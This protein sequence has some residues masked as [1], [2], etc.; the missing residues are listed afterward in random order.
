MQIQLSVYVPKEKVE[1]QKRLTQLGI[2]NEIVALTFLRLDC[3]LAIESK[4]LDE[5]LTMKSLKSATEFIDVPDGR[6]CTVVIELED[7]D[8]ARYL[9]D[10]LN[11]EVVSE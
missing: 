1:K 2:E 4:I 11:G 3:L 9:L 6:V 10:Y 8:L 7:G 5:V